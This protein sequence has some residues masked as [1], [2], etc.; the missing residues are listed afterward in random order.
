MYLLFSVPNNSP[1]VPF[2]G[3]ACKH[4]NIKLDIDQSF[5]YLSIFNVFFFFLFPKRLTYFFK[6]AYK[7]TVYAL[8]IV[9]RYLFALLVYTN[10]MALV[11]VIRPAVL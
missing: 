1:F 7:Y 3:L 4:S 9:C 11:S 10:G 2:S 6:I 8:Q 5:T